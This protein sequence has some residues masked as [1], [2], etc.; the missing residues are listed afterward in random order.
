[1]QNTDQRGDIRLR[2]ESTLVDQSPAGCATERKQGLWARTL[3]NLSVTSLPPPFLLFLGVMAND[4]TGSGTNMEVIANR[5]LLKWQKEKQGVLE[6]VLCT[7]SMTTHTHAV[8]CKPVCVKTSKETADCRMNF[9]KMAVATRHVGHD[10]TSIV[11]DTPGPLVGFCIGRLTNSTGNA[12]L[13]RLY[14]YGWSGPAHNVWLRVL[15]T[16]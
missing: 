12:I 14:F 4:I 13:L 7:I 6:L 8:R 10:H 15:D 5:V 3:L 9:K 2:G 16:T 1:M 11:V